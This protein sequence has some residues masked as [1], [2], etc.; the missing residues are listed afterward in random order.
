MPGQM[1]IWG[2]HIRAGMEKGHRESTGVFL[3]WVMFFRMCRII[4]SA[5]IDQL[6]YLYLY[7]YYIHAYTCILC[8][9][10]CI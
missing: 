6:H 1:D 10:V 2:F 7:N 5:G 9:Y 4:Q 3:P 8:K